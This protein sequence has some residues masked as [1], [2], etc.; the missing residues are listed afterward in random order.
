MRNTHRDYHNN[1]ILTKPDEH[2]YLFYYS[3]QTRQT[4][5]GP[6]RQSSFGVHD[7]R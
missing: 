5:Y 1:L 7:R 2:L 6:Q 3:I 4:K